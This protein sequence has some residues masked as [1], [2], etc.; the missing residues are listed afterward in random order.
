MI[1]ILESIARPNITSEDGKYIMQPIK[2]EMT[3]AE[4]QRIYDKINEIIFAVNKL[5]EANHA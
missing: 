3:Y 5:T 1:D 4:R 2:A